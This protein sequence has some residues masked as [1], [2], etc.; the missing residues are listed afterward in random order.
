MTIK[1]IQV[2]PYLQKL[3]MKGILLINMYIF[4]IGTQTIKQLEK[5][6]QPTEKLLAGQILK[7][8]TKTRICRNEVL[9]SLSILHSSSTLDNFYVHYD[10]IGH[11]EGLAEFQNC[12]K[13]HE[14]FPIK[15]SVLVKHWIWIENSKHQNIKYRV[16]YLGAESMRENSWQTVTS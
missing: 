13:V 5:K 12:M 4:R 7:C 11:K 8:F 6:K 14:Y 3:R 2:N 1:S 9:K 15:R 16:F 10:I